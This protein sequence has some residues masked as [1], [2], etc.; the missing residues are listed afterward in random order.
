MAQT[1][2][3]SDM[4]KAILH[5]PVN[6]EFSDGQY[7][8]RY[9]TD[10]T[11][12]YIHW[13]A[14]DSCNIEIS[15]TDSLLIDA[16]KFFSNLP[17]SASLMDTSL[18]VFYTRL[19]HKVFNQPILYDKAL[20]YFSAIYPIEY[21]VFMVTAIINENNK[22]ALRYVNKADS[23]INDVI[24]NRILSKRIIHKIKKLSS[25]PTVPCEGNNFQV[26]AIIIEYKYQ[27][28][29]NALPFMTF[30]ASELYIKSYK[31]MKKLHKI[32]VRKVKRQ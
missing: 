14:S 1:S 9:Y 11:H 12:Y 10:T 30:E 17:K 15:E 13:T 29:Y 2:D 7:K 26:P 3:I 8:M 21:D 20:N 5:M 25:L 19:F 32:A 24:L 27:G 18:F 4:E 23:S 28:K 31:L 6:L 22:V 16:E